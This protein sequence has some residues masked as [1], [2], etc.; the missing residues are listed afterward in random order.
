VSRPGRREGSGSG[1]EVAILTN[2]RRSDDHD[3]IRR[4][5][6]D[7]VRKRN[8]GEPEFLQAVTEVLRSITP[9][10]DRHPEYVESRLLE[11]IV[12]RSGLS[13]SASRGW[14]TRGRCR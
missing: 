12:D 5:I 1:S 7:T 6:L 13:C 8:A 11:R 9:V 14:T 3:V 10:L 4:S 2:L